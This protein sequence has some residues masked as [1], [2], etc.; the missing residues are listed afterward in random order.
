M[1]IIT[2]KRGYPCWPFSLGSP[3]A[4][5][6]F[7]P[8]FTLDYGD[9]DSAQIVTP[10]LVYYPTAPGTTAPG[11]LYPSGAESS[12]AIVEVYTGHPAKSGWPQTFSRYVQDLVWRG[13]SVFQAVNPA[14]PF[15]GE[16]HAN[17]T[18]AGELLEQHEHVTP[19]RIA[20]NGFSL[21][22]YDALMQ[23]F[24]YPE[25]WGASVAADG[26]T[27][28]IDAGEQHRG[29]PEI[30]QSLGDPG[31]NEDEWRHQNPI[32]DLDRLDSGAGC[33][34]FVWHRL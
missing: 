9:A 33:P 3:L 15:T 18:A 13:Y 32:D 26:F 21:G 31:E 12:P 19:A 24:R 23:A 1:V 2:I 8:I 25:T 27:D 6:I 17:N 28:I 4:I 5:S 7:P 16:L 14:A 34:L 20:A 29:H 11:F 22:G 30:R 10:E